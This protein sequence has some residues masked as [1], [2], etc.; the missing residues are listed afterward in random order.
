[1]TAVAIEITPRVR[2]MDW[3]P[4]TVTASAPTTEPAGFVIAD[5]DEL[6]TGSVQGCG[7]DNPYN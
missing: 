4:L 1:M 7:E 6:T 2:V 3:Q 5:V